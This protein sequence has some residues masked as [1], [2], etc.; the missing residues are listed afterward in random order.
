[1]KRNI[2]LGLLW[3]LCNCT[4]L[5]AQTLRVACV[6]NSITYGSRIENRDTDSYPAVLGRLLG[7][8]YEVENFGLSGRTLSRDAS[9]PYVAEPRYQEALAYR[10]D[11]VVVKLGT[12][13]SQPRYRTPQ[14][15]VQSTLNELIDAFQ[16]A[17][18]EARIYL[19]LPVP[20]FGVND[21]NIDP[22]YLTASIRPWITEV[23]QAR[24]LPL[25]DLYTALNGQGEHFPDRVHPNAAGARMIAEEVYRHID[26]D[27]RCSIEQTK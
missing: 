24:N 6:G 22:D 16:A 1:M 17:N 26:K 7:S 10:P 15:S 27:V 5:H 11:I 19:C 13:D 21:Y 8:G 2:F 4:L 9:R 14:E 3:V 20:A 12:N 23:A 25:I 18:P